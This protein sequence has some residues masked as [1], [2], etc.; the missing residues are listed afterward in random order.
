MLNFKI[1][2][3]F[4]VLILGFVFLSLYQVRALTIP[5]HQTSNGSIG[6]QGTIPSPPPSQGAT[7][8]TPVTGTSFTNM[9]VNV[10]GLCPN[11]LLIKI[12][13]NNVFIGAINCQ[14]G[15][16]NI[17]VDLFSGQND[18]V[19]IDYNNLDE[20]GPDS[21]SVIVNYNNIQLAK[22][23][24]VVS[25]TSN[26]AERGSNPGSTLTWPFNLNGGV[27]PYAVSIDW[28]DGSPAELLS[29]KFAGQFSVNHV[30]SKA[31]IYNV[32]VRATDSNHTQAFLE[33]VAVVN[34]AVINLNQK[35][36][37]NQSQLVSNQKPQII[38]WPIII[39]VPLIFITF[40]IGGRH[41]MY[42]L[43][44]QLEKQREELQNNKN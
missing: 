1:S 7:I 13:S 15:S 31:G 24:S 42:V 17:P 37:T 6:L 2:L 41:Q 36:S 18:L 30:Y 33:V 26:D 38:W 8:A 4:F 20:S 22:F 32:V 21:N 28:G 9:P 14:N 3:I 25:L 34:G 40:W 35:K 27:G 39:L 11:N 12:F 16:Y 23:G 5:A 10:N 19:A 44:R 43:R 29:E